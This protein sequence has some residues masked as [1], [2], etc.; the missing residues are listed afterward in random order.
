MNKKHLL[1][2]ALLF[3]LAASTIT[4][5]AH[6][7]GDWIFRG[8]LTNVAPN[9][10]SSNV[11]VAGAD[12]GVGVSV[13]N[14]TQLG[15]NAAYMLTNNWA[16]EL[17]AATPFSHDITL[18]TVGALGE[19]KHL[20]PTISA[21]YYFGSSDS[22]LKPYVG[23]GLNYTTFFSEEFTSANKDAGFSK[24]SLDDSFGLALQ[25]GADYQINEQWHVNVSA[26]RIDIST[27][28]SFDL[29]GAQGKVS[30]DID[31]S[32]YTFSLGYSF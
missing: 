5:H 24:L 31:P 10:D 22:K 21:N 14:N 26:R 30:V 12:L 16:I 29:N 32:V 28:A 9:D 2:A 13:G 25:I 3:S 17:L 6:E 4:T 19:T 11:F 27:D 23:F 7:A 20:P 18:N 15:I 1:G 8:G